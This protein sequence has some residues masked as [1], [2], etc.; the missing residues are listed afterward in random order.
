MKDTKKRWSHEEIVEAYEELYGEIKNP[1]KSKNGTNETNFKYNALTAMLG[2][3]LRELDQ[4]YKSEISIAQTLGGGRG[5]GY[6][7]AKRYDCDPFYREYGY[8]PELRLICRFY[9]VC[10]QLKSNKDLVLIWSFKE[11]LKKITFYSTTINNNGEDEL[12]D[13]KIWEQQVFD[14]IECYIDKLDEEGKL[15]LGVSC[16]YDRLNYLQYKDR[17]VIGVDITKEMDGILHKYRYLCEYMFAIRK[18]D[19]MKKIR[20]YHKEINNRWVYMIDELETT[21]DYQKKDGLTEGELF[22]KAEEIYKL[23]NLGSKNSKTGYSRMVGK[24][25][26]DEA[27]R[28][29][30]LFSKLEKDDQR[31]INQKFLSELQDWQRMVKYILRRVEALR[32]YDMVY[33]GISQKGAKDKISFSKKARY[34]FYQ[35][36]SCEDELYQKNWQKDYE[37]W[38]ER[39]NSRKL[40]SYLKDQYNKDWETYTKLVIYGN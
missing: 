35:D 24:K 21:N 31:C 37:E 13:R 1:K 22:H 16:I 9:F 2:T 29:R 14:A 17:Q 28:T 34:K 8:D 27:E 30:K 19:K 26:E 32:F 15:F 39:L 23:K 5:K 18:A 7:I 38:T 6:Y 25:M 36:N 3:I 10:S 40:Y 11:M 33:Y 12:I 4:A 20:N